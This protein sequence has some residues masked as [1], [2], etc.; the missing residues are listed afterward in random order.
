MIFV[1]SFLE[2]GE[3][4]CEADVENAALLVNLLRPVQ[5]QNLHATTQNLLHLAV[6]KVGEF[7]CCLTATSR[8]SFVQK[9]AAQPVWSRVDRGGEI[10]WTLRKSLVDYYHAAIVHTQPDLS[11]L[12]GKV[13]TIQH[14]IK[15]GIW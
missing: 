3:W 4:P 1:W 6:N 15:L 9:L 13:E 14:D 11:S 2:W 7:F 5:S 8:S 12:D 10:M